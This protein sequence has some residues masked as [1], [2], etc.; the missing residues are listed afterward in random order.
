MLKKRILIIDDDSRNIFAL[1]ATL[2]ARSFDCM[3]CTS[4][5]EAL[6]L[7]R[8]NENV[9]AILI[10]MM[11][12]EMDGYEAIPRIKNIESRAKTPIIAVTAQAMVGDR[13]KCL[14]AG[15]SDY[16][17]KPVDVDRLLQLL[18]QV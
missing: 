8:T 10:D 15:A 14:Q 2:K 1:S 16:I 7:L 17:S 4:A 12:P 6:E 18:S 9:D 13:E 3:S 5:H 11:M